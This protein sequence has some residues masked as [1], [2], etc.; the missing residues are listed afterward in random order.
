MAKRVRGSR[1][2][3]RPGGQGPSRTTKTTGASTS[4]ADDVSQATTDPDID[5]TVDTIDAEYTELATEEVPRA[6]TPEPK[7]ARRAGRRAKAKPDDL[8]ARSAAENVWVRE[9]LRRIGIVSVVLFV[10]LALAWVVFVALDV[11]SLY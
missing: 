2:T 4:A 1:S 10:S 3:H 9:D 11:L 5:T 6:S 8:A 7:K